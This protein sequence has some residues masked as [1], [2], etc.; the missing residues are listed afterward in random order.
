MQDGGAVVLLQ[1]CKWHVHLLVRHGGAAAAVAYILIMRLVLC[2]TYF[3]LLPFH[4]FSQQH[5]TLNPP[6]T[7]PKNTTL[8]PLPDHPVFVS[9]HRLHV[10]WVR[11]LIRTQRPVRGA[12]KKWNRRLPHPSD[13]LNL[14]LSLIKK[15]FLLL[16]SF[17]H[18]HYHYVFCGWV[19]S[20]IY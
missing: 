5:A 18:F 19:I 20:E 9:L 7:C 17:P 8:P 2:Y 6:G 12:K 15:M 1:L 11:G 4:I 13:A 10:K 16:F 14:I 3:T